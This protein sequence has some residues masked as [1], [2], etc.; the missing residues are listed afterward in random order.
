MPSLPPTATPGKEAPPLTRPRPDDGGITVVAAAGAAVVLLAAALLA[1][2]GTMNVTATCQAQ[3]PPTA[4]AT[5]TI[6]PGY[7]ADYRAAGARYGIPWTILA[8]IGEVETDH[9]RSGAPGV[10][11]GANPAGAAG[12][13][14]FG[15]G[16]LAGN[17]WGGAPVHPASQH[18]GGYGTDGDHDGIVNVYDPG[19]AIPSAAAYLRAHGAPASIPAAVFAYNHSA[20]YVTD[21]LNWA[22]RYGAG[23]AR[24]TAAQAGPACHQAYLGPLPGGVAGKILAYA[25][26]QL[27][28]PYQ[29]GATGPDAFD[30]SGLAM[31]GYRAAGIFIPRTS[32]EQWAAGPQIPSSRVRPGDLVFFAGTDGTLT[33]PGHVGIVTSPGM[34]IDA[35]ATGQVVRE[36]RYAGSPDPVGFTSPGAIVRRLRRKRDD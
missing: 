31:Q 5:S 9:G 8:A 33:A 27:G 6:P 32:Q 18:A 29:W 36:E 10:H 25:E 23:G 16:G 2:A 13:M 28:K 24:L 1:A 14:Q 7:L 20:A 22:G 4:T 34:M 15:I 19:D 21:V 11:S 30:C 35:P 26:A 12:P 17:T 3:A